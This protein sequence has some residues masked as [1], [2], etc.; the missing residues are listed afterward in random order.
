MIL[1]RTH[2]SPHVDQVIDAIPFCSDGGLYVIYSLIVASAKMYLEWYCWCT[3]CFIRNITIIWQRGKTQA[4]IEVIINEGTINITI[5]SSLAY[6]K[7]N[8]NYMY[9]QYNCIPVFRKHSF[10]IIIGLC[11]IDKKGHNIFWGVVFSGTSNYIHSQL[12][13]TWWESVGIIP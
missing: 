9:N 8:P 7:K 11:F 1:M 13:F 10:I 6:R 2:F 4:V 3:S 5:T 12:L